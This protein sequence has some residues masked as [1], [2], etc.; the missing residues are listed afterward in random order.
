M[1]GVGRL[2]NIPGIAIK[3][4]LP[5]PNHPITMER[6]QFLQIAVPGALALS[7]PVTSGLHWHRFRWYPLAQPGLLT[8]LG[9][10]RRVREIGLAYRHVFPQEDDQETLASILLSDCG[11]SK[12]LANATLQSRLD[13]RIRMDFTNGCT[14]QLNGWILSVTE[15]RQSAL[16]S[17]LY[18]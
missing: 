12:P 3:K 8:I 15:A 11:V 13:Q 7:L 10:E 2:E 14:V 4:G 18:S 9:D 17:L 6:R 16:F 1:P 5:Q